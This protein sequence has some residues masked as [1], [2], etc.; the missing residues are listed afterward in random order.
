MFSKCSYLLIRFFNSGQSLFLISFIY[1]IELSELCQ[2][3]K[4]VPTLN[5]SLSRVLL[6]MAGG[7]LA[8]LALVWERTRHA[9]LSRVRQ[10]REGMLL[11]ASPARKRIFISQ[12]RKL[13]TF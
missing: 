13:K 3:K 4:R 8:L 10:A 12:R 5:A 2:I 11:N 7:R 6:K 9:I 1:C